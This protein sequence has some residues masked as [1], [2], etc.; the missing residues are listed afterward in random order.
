MGNSKN[1]ILGCFPLPGQAVPGRSAGSLG[2]KDAGDP[3]TVMCMAGDTPGPV[4][5]GGD[6][7]AAILSSEPMWCEAPVPVLAVDLD[8]MRQFLFVVAYAEETDQAATRGF[9]SAEVNLGDQ[10]KVEAAAHK[11]ADKLLEQFQQTFESGTDAVRSFI[12]ALDERKARARASLDTK[13]AEALKVGSRWV[14]VFGWT[15]KGLSTVKFASTVTIKTLS[16][17]TG[18]AGTGIDWAYSGAQAGLKEFQSDAS[19]QNV[20]GVVVDETGKNFA[21]EIG[22]KFNELVAEGL[23][24]TAEKNRI[25]GLI[26][27]YKGSTKKL[28]EQIIEL[29]KK[30]RKAMEAGKGGKKITGLTLRSSEKLAKLRALREKTLGAV[31]RKG[32]RLGVAKK[33]AGKTLSLVFLAAEVKDAWKEAAEEWRNSN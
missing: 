32:T 28:Q 5:T 22:E 16:L 25:A 9:A 1:R 19:E 23:M 21:Q 2:W 18:A 8:K 3:D 31:L 10:P 24:T 26:G 11:A 7:G 29:E 15:V 4:G 30:I 33:A 17:F 6:A 13:F 14:S 27:N 20:S 12:S